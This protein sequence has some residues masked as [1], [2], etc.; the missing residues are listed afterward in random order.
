M[1]RVLLLL[2]VLLTAS[3]APAE[4]PVYFAD[5]NLKTVVEPRQGIA[6]HRKVSE[7]GKWET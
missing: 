3:A 4:G 1:K 2:L 6:G 7:C 5:Q